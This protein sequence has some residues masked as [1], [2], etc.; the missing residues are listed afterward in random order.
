[1]KRP[2][3]IIIIILVVILAFPV[4][5]VVRWAFQEKKPLNVLVLNK[6]VPTLDRVT[7]RSFFW[8]LNNE[9]FVDKEKKNSY[10]YRND[11]YGFYPLKP[12]RE[13][14]HKKV[15]YRLAELID[16]AESYD[17]LYF[18]D[19]YGVFFSEWYQTVNRTRR[20]R[21]IYGGLNNNDQLLLAE[22]QKREKLI[23]LEYNSFDYPTADLERYKVEEMLGIKSTGWT[24]KYFESLDTVNNQDF[25]IWMTGMYRKY[26]RE[27]WTFTGPG[28]V[29]VKSREIVVLEMGESLTSPMPMV[30]TGEENAAKYGVAVSVPFD[31]WFEVIEPRDSEV[32]SSFQINATA[33]GDSLL[34]QNFLPDNFPAVIVNPGNHRSF[35]FA[36]DFATNDVPIGTSYLSKHWILRKTHFSEK[37]ENDPKR[38]F[39]LYYKPLITSIF[40]DY[41]NTIK[42]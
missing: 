35:Y 15:D 26:T 39:W 41:Y 34:A 24:G 31:K 36:G 23:L 9:R 30:I 10:S 7:H 1:M 21:K 27:P 14:Q 40:T 3:L 32:I 20:T 28:I 5:S 4:Y 12:L 17:A 19:T 8:I 16:L 38:F 18:A 13:R 2:L 25:P 33:A 11:Y 6:T 29:F 42:Q 37:D 22:M